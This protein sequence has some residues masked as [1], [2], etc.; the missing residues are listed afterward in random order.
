M[1]K[2]E[3]FFEAYKHMPN[4]PLDGYNP[5][6]KSN[7]ATLKGILETVKKT[8]DHYG[9]IYTQTVTTITAN[10][11]YFP[12]LHTEVA[13]KDGD[14]ESLGF[15]PLQVDPNPQKMG[16]YLTYLRRYAALTD[17][18]IVGEKDQDGEEYLTADA[19]ELAQAKGALKA[20]ITKWAANTDKDADEVF[21]QVTAH[22][23]ETAQWYLAKA[24]EVS[25]YVE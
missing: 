19:Q 18:G 5:H 9:L 23:E 6:F 11:D 7:F 24:E 2:T 1:S 25:G 10:G 16:A 14:S 17:W 13:S 21:K 8:L 22:A 20:E 12:V 4:P 15:Y 3:N